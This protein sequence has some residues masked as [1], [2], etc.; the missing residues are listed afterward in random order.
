[1]IIHLNSPALVADLFPVSE[2]GRALGMV[3]TIVASG[4]TIGPALGGLILEYTSW[5]R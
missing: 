3:G 4:L 1:M 5:R 2:R